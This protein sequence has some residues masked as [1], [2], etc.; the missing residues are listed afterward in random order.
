MDKLLEIR[1]GDGNHVSWSNHSPTIPSTIRSTCQRIQARFSSSE[2]DLGKCDATS[3]KID[4][5]P[6]SK[7][8]KIPNR[9]MPLDYKEDLQSKLDAFL[10]KDLIAPCHSPYSSPAMLVPEKNGKVRLV[11]EYRQLNKQTVKSSWS[12]PS[13]EEIFDTLGGSCYFSTSDMSAG[14]Y[15]VPMDKDSQD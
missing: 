8:I 11:F 2:W 10:K 15:Q 4:V 5:H 3:H 1:F 7:P 12:I 13:I 14:F 9:R 6:G